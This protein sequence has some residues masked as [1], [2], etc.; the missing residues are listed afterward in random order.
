MIT[1][2]FHQCSRC[3]LFR[4]SVDNPRC[5]GENRSLGARMGNPTDHP[6]GHGA[7]RAMVSF[8]WTGVMLPCSCFFF[9]CT[10]AWLLLR[11]ALPCVL[12]SDLWLRNVKK[13]KRMLNSGG[14]MAAW[15]SP[16]EAA[17]RAPAGRPNTAGRRAARRGGR[18][19]W[20]GTD[21]QTARL[22]RETASLTRLVA[23]TCSH[24][25]G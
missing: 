24:A 25:R 2:L 4:W 21:C 22:K 6:W 18:F 15:P 14:G 11:W 12:L 9:F 13:K 19:W 23:G 17:R 3:P 7:Q 16:R 5:G 20:G 8:R 1:L 10:A